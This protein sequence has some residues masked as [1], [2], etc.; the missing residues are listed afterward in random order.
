[1]RQGQF[2]IAAAALG[3]FAAGPAVATV[4]VEEDFEDDIVDEST[5]LA[6]EVDENDDPIPDPFFDETFPQRG[7]GFQQ[8]QLLHINNPPD[9]NNNGRPGRWLPNQYDVQALGFTGDN[10]EWFDPLEINPDNNW[11]PAVVRDFRQ[12]PINPDSPPRPGNE[13]FIINHH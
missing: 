2:W 4:V 8:N 12:M 3:L 5:F 7:L 13:G 11:Q 10:G 6:F 1:M 9:P